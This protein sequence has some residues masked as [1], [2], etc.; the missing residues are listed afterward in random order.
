MNP[1][2]RTLEPSNPRTR[3]PANP[4]TREAT[5]PLV[6][7]PSPADPLRHVRACPVLLAWWRWVAS[8]PEAITI[9]RVDLYTMHSQGPFAEGIDNGQI[10]FN[11]FED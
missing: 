6:A 5:P 1:R 4:R 3:E 11:N 9:Y 2:P 8:L 7:L 10:S